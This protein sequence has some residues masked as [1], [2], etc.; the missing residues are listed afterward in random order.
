MEHILADVRRIQGRLLLSGLCRKVP[1]FLINLI[2]LT[3]DNQ[4]NNH[5]CNSAAGSLDGFHLV[6][7]KIRQIELGPWPL[8]PKESG[9]ID[10]VV[11]RRERGG[12]QSRVA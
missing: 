10:S 2:H 8:T 5:V 6:K 1:Q 9:R 4:S 11:L 12:N 7:Q 3:S